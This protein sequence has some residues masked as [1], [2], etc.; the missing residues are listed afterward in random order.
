MTAA[1]CIWPRISVHNI[2]PEVSMRM[3]GSRWSLA[4]S[5]ILPLLWLIHLREGPVLLQGRNEN[6]VSTQKLLSQFLSQRDWKWTRL[7]LTNVHRYEGQ[8]VAGGVACDAADTQ[9][10]RVNQTLLVLI[11]VQSAP[12]AGETRGV[13]ALYLNEALW[14]AARKRERE[15][16]NLSS[17]GPPIFLKHQC[18]HQHTKHKT[19]VQ[20]KALHIRGH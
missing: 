11:V 5:H 20:V 1:A 16:F 10:G 3:E 9:V 15:T 14:Q 18:W 17:V 2:C 12:T 19:N 7:S 8:H 4:T 6:Q 13:R